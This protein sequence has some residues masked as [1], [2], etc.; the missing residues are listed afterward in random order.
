MIKGAIYNLNPL[1]KDETAQGWERI[2]VLDI[3]PYKTVTYPV[4]ENGW[5]CSDD[6]DPVATGNFTYY[7]HICLVSDDNSGG[8]IV[9]LIDDDFYGDIN[10]NY[11][12]VNGKEL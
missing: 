5:R 2:K 9:G 8:D 6:D 7:E 4:N 11:I 10:I 12:L 1:R 3:R